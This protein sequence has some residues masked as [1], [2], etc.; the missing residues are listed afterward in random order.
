[1]KGYFFAFKLLLVHRLTVRFD[2]F[3]ED[4]RAFCIWRLLP[5]LCNKLHESCGRTPGVADCMEHHHVIVTAI[6]WYLG[7]MYRLRRA[8]LDFCSDNHDIYGNQLDPGPR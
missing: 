7:S 5:F 1:M 4:L 3:F 2:V 6:F 8:V